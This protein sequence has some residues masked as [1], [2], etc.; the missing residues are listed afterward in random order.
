M[1]FTADNSGIIFYANRS[2]HVFH[3][4]ARCSTPRQSFVGSQTINPF[5][6]WKNYKGSLKILG[7]F[8]DKHL[9]FLL[10]ECIFDL[11]N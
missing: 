8:I 10:N 7:V 9:I 3:L 1:L 11:F 4:A 6:I 2:C 5:K